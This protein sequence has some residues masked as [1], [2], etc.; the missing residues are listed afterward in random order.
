M[1]RAAVRMAQSGLTGQVASGKQEQRATV[2][3]TVG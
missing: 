2:P 3:I 1:A